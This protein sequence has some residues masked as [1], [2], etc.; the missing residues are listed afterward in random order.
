M[1]NFKKLKRP[2][3]K[4]PVERI[5]EDNRALVQIRSSRSPKIGTKLNLEKYTVECIDR[6][7]NF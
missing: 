6:N 1:S 2:H 7:E 3:A 5:M 4:H